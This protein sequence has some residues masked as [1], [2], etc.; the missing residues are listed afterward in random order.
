MKMIL[1]LLALLLPLSLLAAELPGDSSPPLPRRWLYLQTGLLPKEHMVQTMA[2]LERVAAEGYTGVL[3]SD[4]KFMRWDSVP[5][6][7]KKNWQEMHDTCRRLK[8]ELVAAVMPMGYSNSLLSR[9]PHLAEGLP[10]RGATFVVRNGTLIPDETISFRNGGF[11]SFHANTPDGW[12]FVDAPGQISFMDTTIHKEGHASLRMQDVAKFEPEHKHARV[13]QTLKL[14]PFHN[15]H[16]SV[17]VKTLNWV[18]QDTRIMVLGEKG[19]TLNFQTPVFE[20]TQDWKT[21]HITFN[22]LESSAV[23]LYLGTWAGET[24]TIWWDNV[25]VE[26]AGFMNVLRRPGAPLRLY[27]EGGSVFY[28]EG[29]DVQTINDPLLGMDPWAG[30][31]SSWHALPAIHTLTGGQL[32]EGQRVLADYYH[33]TIIY[34]GQ[35]SC[36]MSEAK[37]Y[38]ILTEQIQ[39]VRDAIHPDGYMMMHDEIRVQGWDESCQKQGGD[40]SRI[41]GNNVR[42]CVDIIKAADP[43]KPL[44][45]W[46][47]MFDPTHN[48]RK[49]GRYYLVKGEGP[50][51]GAWKDL[52][53]EVTVV[54]WQM[55]QKT[56][57][58]SLEHFAGL[59]HK[60]ILAGYYDGDPKMI[61]SWLKDAKGIKGVNGVM[62]TTWQSN[63][64]HTKEFIDSANLQ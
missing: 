47:D 21:I 3:F 49:T 53:A 2:L 22:T 61:T 51:Y 58:Q 13:C 54:S 12:K 37:V 23:T 25:R 64:K 41:L 63:F 30:D 11:E 33:T 46:S 36:C 6:I 14:Q 45:I 29:R 44:F 50:W 52:P 38:E 15:Y 39:Q 18:A 42:H 60:Q 26:P 35:V 27:N 7:Y 62:Y 59:G 1:P 31:Y 48:A 5:D 8:L 43:G 9:D 24:G 10:V 28:Q 56:R 19:Q 34:D 40:P 32:A 20:Q 55:D 17:D 57:R 4:Y 16:V